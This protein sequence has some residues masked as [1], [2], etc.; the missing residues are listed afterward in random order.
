MAFA[1]GAAKAPNHNAGNIDGRLGRSTST[2]KL[3]ETNHIEHVDTFVTTFDVEAPNHNKGG[4]LYS[5]GKLVLMPAPTRD[6]RD[7]LNMTTKHKAICAFFLCFFGALAAAAELI[8]GAML[9]V[10]ALEYAGYDPKL[11]LPWSKS[12][13]LFPPGS[14]PLKYLAHL[15]EKEPPIIVIYMLAS[16]PILIVGLSNLVLIPLAISMGRRAILLIC[17]VLA[18]VGAIWAGF[19]QSIGSHL[20]A[21]CLQ[22][23]GAGTCM[24]ISPRLQLS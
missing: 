4:Q 13:V 23:L 24:T 12:T 8:L 9:P 22:A 17:G 3:Y 6:P 16:L 10:F 15:S 18:I 5:D 1:A 19:S 11:L 14:D 2:E 20:G 21:R 7:P